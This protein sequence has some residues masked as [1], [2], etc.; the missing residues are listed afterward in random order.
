M[1][2]KMF[3]SIAGRMRSVGEIEE[4]VGRAKRMLKRIKAPDD[5]VEELVAQFRAVAIKELTSA[6]PQKD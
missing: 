4:A 6:R 3:R 5:V 2:E 1:D